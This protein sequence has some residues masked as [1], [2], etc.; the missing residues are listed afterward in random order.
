MLVTVAAFTEPWEAHIFRGRL[1]AE[2]IFAVVSH[3]HFVG[4]NWPYALALG[5]AKV[6]VHRMDREKAL[7]VERQCRTGE[8]QA[9]LAATWPDFGASRCPRCDAGQIAHRRSLP[10][11]VFLLYT[12]YLTDQIFPLRSSVH[13]CKAC[14]ARWEDRTEPIPFPGP[15]SP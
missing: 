4:Q 13:R 11:L 15:W 6:Q 8:L 2:D 3:D 1:L 7:A 5:G 12:A 10:M 9:E 14:G